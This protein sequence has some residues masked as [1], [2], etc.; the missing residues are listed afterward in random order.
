[1]AMRGKM[2]VAISGTSTGKK[3]S[4]E[5]LWRLVKGGEEE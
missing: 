3:K 2:F 5:R 1:V 4:A